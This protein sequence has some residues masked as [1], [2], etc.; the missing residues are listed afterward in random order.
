MRSEFVPSK[1]EQDKLDKVLGEY[2][3]V[4]SENPGRTEAMTMSIRTGDH[5][6]VRSHPT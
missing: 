4:L 3:D 5:E 1:G 6:P 2:S